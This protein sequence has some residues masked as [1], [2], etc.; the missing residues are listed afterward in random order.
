[1][2]KPQGLGEVKPGQGYPGFEVVQ[3]NNCGINVFHQGQRPG[4]AQNVFPGL[5]RDA[6]N[7]S[8]N[9]AFF[10]VVL[11]PIVKANPNFFPVVGHLQSSGNKFVRGF[12][13]FRVNLKGQ[14][15]LKNRRK[16]AQYRP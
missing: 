1:M 7:W 15:G 9:L 13:G 16:P 11:H 4:K 12:S 10:Q 14:L 8:E 5:G 6:G 2:K 3:G